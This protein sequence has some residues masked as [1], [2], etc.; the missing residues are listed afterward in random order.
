MLSICHLTGHHSIKSGFTKYVRVDFVVCAPT[1]YGHGVFH[2]VS[3]RQHTHYASGH[4]ISPGVP[5]GHRTAQRGYGISRRVATGH[6]TAQS[7]YGII[8]GVATTALSTRRAWHL[9]QDIAQHTANIASTKG[10][11]TRQH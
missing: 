10:V 6:R 8:R 5:I 2:G 11:P 9:P 3:L 1:H 4:G 7:G